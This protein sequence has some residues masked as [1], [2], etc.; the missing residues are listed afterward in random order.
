MNLRT[1]F[2]VLFFLLAGAFGYLQLHEDIEVPLA[3]PFHEFPASHGDWRMVSQASLS[4]DVLNILKPTDYLS[5]RYL[6]SDGRAVDFYLSYFDGG[7]DTGGIHSPKHCLPGSG[8]TEFSSRRITVDVDGQGVNLVKA[9]YGIGNT[10]EL[11]LYWFDIRGQ[12][13][14]DEYSL[15]L[16][17]IVGSALHRRRDE[18]FIR[19]SVPVDGDA[20]RAFEQGVTFIKDFYPVIR[21]FL[22]S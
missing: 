14:S 13:L 8:W 22:P 5:R 16:M 10:R 1:R 2:I 17:E 15:K 20:E 18:S 4:A 11:L 3:R 21:E 19:I 7:K 12:T 6:G 9:V